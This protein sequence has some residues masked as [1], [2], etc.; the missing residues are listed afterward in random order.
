MSL[1]PFKYL[2]YY[3]PIVAKRNA[4]TLGISQRLTG[5]ILEKDGKSR[6]QELVYFKLSEEYDISEANR[7]LSPGSPPRRPFGPIVGELRI[8]F[9]QYLSAENVTSYDPSVNSFLS[10]Y[11]MFIFK[12]SRGDSL[13]LEYSWVSGVVDQINA[14]LRVRLHS[15]LDAVYGKRY[16]RQDKQSLETVYGA[17]YRHQCWTVDLSFSEKPALAGQPAEKKF[18]F[19]I[20]LLGVTSVGAR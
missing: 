20:N 14:W 7:D 5:K 12:D 6:Y 19:Q 8:N 4:L 2:S 9:L 17:Q 16:S 10:S 15:S 3:D 18:L 11:S 13:N 1:I